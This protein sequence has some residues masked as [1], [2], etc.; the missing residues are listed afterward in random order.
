MTKQQFNIKITTDPALF[1]KCF[2]C[3]RTIDLRSSKS[4]HRF[5]K[6]TYYCIYCYFSYC[7]YHNFQ[8]HKTNGYFNNEY[9][10]FIEPE[11]D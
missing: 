8:Y 3:K 2:I 6:K 9:N 1:K 4:Y 11:S 5:N 7:G 10:R